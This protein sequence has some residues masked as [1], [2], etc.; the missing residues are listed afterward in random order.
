M[1]T[2]R[3]SMIMGTLAMM[4][5]SAMLASAASEATFTMVRSSTAVTAGCLPN[6]AGRVTIHT[7]G[8]V[9][10]MHVEATGL[11]ANTGF[12]FFVIQVP[13]APFGMSWYQGDISTD[14]TGKGVGDFVGRFSIETFIVAPGVAP[15]PVVHTAAPFPDASSNPATAPV[16]MFHLGLWFDKP[17]AAAAAG[18]P[19][20]ETPFNGNHTAGVQAMSTRNFTDANGP[21]RKIN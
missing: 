17:T 13:D 15:A 2:P 21:L 4:L 1:K 8:P 5:T 9:E 3:S 16:H 6:A 19:N 14:S 11:P 12:D 18:C 7:V 10:F 20:T